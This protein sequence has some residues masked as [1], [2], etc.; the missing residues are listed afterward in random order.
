MSDFSDSNTTV[1]S[2]DATSLIPNP[3]GNVNIVLRPLGTGSFGLNLSDGTIA[4]GNCRGNNAVDL[5]K[6]RGSA[7]QVASGVSSFLGGTGSCK[8]TGINSVVLGGYLGSATGTRSACMGGDSVTCQGQDAVICGGYSN[9]I[10]SNLSNTSYYDAICGG[11]NNTISAGSTGNVILGGYFNNIKGMYN[12]IASGYACRIGGSSSSPTHCFVGGREAVSDYS[13]CFVWGDNSGGTY[14]STTSDQFKARCS[15]GVFLRS[16]APPIGATGVKITSG[17]SSWSSYLPMSVKENV[18]EID[19][20]DLLHRLSL[21]PTS[22][23]ESKKDDCIHISATGEEF[24]R[25]FDL[26]DD[27][28]DFALYGKEKSSDIKKGIDEG[29]A[30]AVNFGALQGILSEIQYL[31][32]EIREFTSILEEKKKKS[33]S[34]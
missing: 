33:S 14:S 9:L 4:N 31:E 13:G 18:E 5:Q 23:W 25:L 29:D 6:S 19:P 22:I 30:D 24:N 16:T 27:A 7:D 26:E 8:A 3:T 34:I 2:K 28:D 21:L 20:R 32:K 17:S 1:C 11:Q 15:G 10:D 12:C